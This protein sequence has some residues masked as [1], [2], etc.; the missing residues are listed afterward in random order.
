MLARLAL[1]CQNL[2]LHASRRQASCPADRDQSR[3]SRVFS[4]VNWVIFMLT[5]VVFVVRAEAAG[6]GQRVKGTQRRT[7]PLCLCSRGWQGGRMSRN[8]RP[9]EAILD[10]NH[11]PCT[12]AL[13]GLPETHFRIELPATPTK[14]SSA[15]CSTRNSVDVFSLSPA[16]RFGTV[17][18]YREGRK[19]M[20]PCTLISP[21]D[22]PKISNRRMTV[23]HDKGNFSE[24]SETLLGF[25]VFWRPRGG[26]EMR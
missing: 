2:R 20:L 7:R 22:P 17:R 19:S 24:P 18:F 13:P 9:N 23:I 1:G 16:F 5:C 26:Q 25:A 10:R 3:G 11:S 4:L 6:S 8:R 12:V 21:A 14:H 15:T